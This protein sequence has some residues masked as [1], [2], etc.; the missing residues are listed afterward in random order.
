MRFALLFM[1]G[2][3]SRPSVL[4]ADLQ[5]EVDEAEE[6]EQRQEDGLVNQVDNQRAASQKL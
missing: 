5:T 3:W 2:S 1:R 4:Q 6:G